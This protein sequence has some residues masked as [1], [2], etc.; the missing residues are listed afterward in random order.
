M[1]AGLLMLIRLSFI[2]NLAALAFA[3][4]GKTRRIAVML[5]MP[6]VVALCLFQWLTFGSP[7]KTGYDYWLPGMKRFAWPNATAWAPPG[8][9]DSVF[10]DI[11]HGKLMRWACP[12]PDGGSQA[13]LP[14][15]IFYPSILV[16]MFWVSFPAAAALRM[17]V[18][19]ATSPRGTRGSLSGSSA[20][21]LYFTLSIC[22]RAHVSL[23]RRQ[24]Y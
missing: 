11:L 2:V 9:G 14:N 1:L 8:D 16:G 7:I 3:L 15:S 12:C 24:H 13:A 23:H 17:C 18:A 20:S 10:P 22:F 6:A 5:A 4:R 19:V 21:R